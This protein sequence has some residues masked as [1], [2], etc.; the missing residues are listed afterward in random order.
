M[1][2]RHILGIAGGALVAALIAGALYAS[3]YWAVHEIREAANDRDIDALASFVDAAALRD[4]VAQALGLQVGT[5]ADPSAEGQRRPDAAQQALAADWL[6]QLGESMASPPVLMGMLIEG[7]LS[8]VLVG[9][10]TAGL[11]RPRTQQ[12]PQADLWDA[13]VRYRDWSTVVV[14][15]KDAPDLGGFVFKRAG[16]FGWKLSGFDLPGP[17]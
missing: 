5:V 11:A 16:L 14:R 3:P 6:G 1:K 7:R 17:R 13:S 12:D 9:D 4:S 8:R 15:A 10:V 2:R